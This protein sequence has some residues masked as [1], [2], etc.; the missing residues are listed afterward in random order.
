MRW[1]T[2]A[3]DFAA[4]V[5]PLGAGRDCVVN[6]SAPDAPDYTRRFFHAKLY[7]FGAEDRPM[8]AT[9]LELRKGSYAWRLVNGSF[10][11]RVTGELADGARVLGS[12][13]FAVKEERSP[14]T[15]AL[16]LPP[17][18]LVEFGVFADDGA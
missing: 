13:S 18:E 14:R 8:S 10:A 4:L 1:G 5:T 17:Q 2:R 16:R 7:H 12:G 3:V 11:D 6:A 15:V 9:L